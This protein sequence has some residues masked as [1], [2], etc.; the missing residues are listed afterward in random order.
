M[1]HG[2]NGRRAKPIPSTWER[3]TLTKAGKKYTY[4]GWVKAY[5]QAFKETDTSHLHDLIRAYPHFAREYALKHKMDRNTN[6]WYFK[7]LPEKHDKHDTTATPARFSIRKHTYHGRDGFLVYRSDGK[8]S[9][10]IYNTRVFVYTREEAEHAR[11]RLKRG[12]E[13][14]PAPKETKR[15]R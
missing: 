8:G 13:P 10:G 3:H 4:L 2:S 6:P 12:E 11:E 15:V 14:F 1:A 7:S 9:R 5:H